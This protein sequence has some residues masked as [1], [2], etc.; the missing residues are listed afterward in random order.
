VPCPNCNSE[1]AE[2][3]ETAHRCETCGWL[4]LV[5]GLWHPC[6]E[7][8]K[9]TD[10]I[11]PAVAEPVPPQPAEPVPGDLPTNRD[12]LNSNVRSYLGGL[13]TVTETKDDDDDDQ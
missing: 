7:P 2:H 11:V 8:S 13:V 10:T 3:R 12:R 5:D 1:F 9:P 4:K 6:P